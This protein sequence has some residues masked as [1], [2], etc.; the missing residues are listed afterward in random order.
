MLAQLPIVINAANPIN[1][2]APLNRGLVFYTRLFSNGP[3]SP[4]GLRNLVGSKEQPTRTGSSVVLGRGELLK[5]PGIYQNAQVEWLEYPRSVNKFSS[6]VTI[7]VI[8]TPKQT[9]SVYRYI[10][11]TQ[12]G[13]ILA[14]RA[15]KIRVIS[16]A[17]TGA[18]F[19]GAITITSGVTY[20]ITYTFSQTNGGKIYINGVLDGGTTYSGI[21]LS[22]TSPLRIGSDGVNGMSG[23]L[24]ETRMYNRELS[25]DEVRRL[26]FSARGGYIRE[27]N[28]LDRPWLLNTVTS[29]SPITQ[30]YPIFD[31]FISNKQ[32]NFKSFIK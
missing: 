7:S 32:T 1:A 3:H 29:Q 25:A 26:Y 27:T 17:I 8:L 13:F 31:S 6:E 4:G 21:P 14:V 18:I 12:A 28:W 16:N 23:L 10:S 11:T 30:Q 2:K 5:G 19:T 24:E 20:Q 22:T 9:A 15:A